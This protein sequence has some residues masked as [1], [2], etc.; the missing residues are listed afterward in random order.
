MAGGIAEHP[1]RPKV[2]MRPQ[3]RDFTTSQ[4]P[5]NHHGPGW[6]PKTAS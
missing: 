3:R 5:A 2:S 4:A 1:N 6:K